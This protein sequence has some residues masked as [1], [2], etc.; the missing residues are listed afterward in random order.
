MEAK[1][2]MRVGGEGSGAGDEERDREERIIDCVSE[3]C[4][5]KGMLLK[6]IELRK[7]L[8]KTS[9]TLCSK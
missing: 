4:G 1:L 7:T 2:P 8:G 3:H 6:R 9:K 5:E